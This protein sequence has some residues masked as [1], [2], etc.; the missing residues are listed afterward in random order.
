MLLHLL[1]AV[2]LGVL[3]HLGVFIRGEWHL[4]GPA[5]VLL[6]VALAACILGAET[7]N[8]PER[9]YRSLGT[10]T[11]LFS[12]YLVGL[13]S[14]ISVY[15]LFFHRLRHFP[16]PRLA[17]LTKIWHVYRCRDSRNHLVLNSWYKQYGAF[18]RTGESAHTCLFRLNKAVSLTLSSKVRVRLPC[19]ILPRSRQWMERATTTQD[20]IG[21]T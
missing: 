10:V 21:M 13:F 8:H 18:V 6:H 5:V 14:S 3:A 7:W 15:R 9:R 2:L 1:L 17:A 16:G 12:C 11:V 19:F 4:R 20:Q